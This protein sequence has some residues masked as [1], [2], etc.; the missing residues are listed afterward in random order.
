[1]RMK[2]REM[3][4]LVRVAETGSMTL[5]AQQMSLTPAAVSGALQRIESSIGIR[6]FERTTRSIR[7]TEEGQ[8]LLEGCHDLTQR[9]HQL[10]ED[11]RGQRIGL[12]GTV[13]VSAPTDTSYRI[14]APILVHLCEQHPKLRV[15]LGISDTVHH[16]HREGIDIAIR[17]GPLQDSSLSARKLVELPTIMVAAPSYIDRYG[18]PHHPEDLTTHRCVTLQMSDFMASWSL[19]R[20]NE[21][22]NVP[23]EVPL[24]GDGFMVRELAVDGWGI[25]LK[26]LFDV[27][28]DLEAG[29]LVR[30][31]PEYV[32][33]SLAIHAVFPS[34][35]Y[36]PARVRAF[37]SAIDTA[38]AERAARC[39]TWLQHSAG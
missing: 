15:L 13:H 5:A 21:R 39:E 16:M 14:L 18:R 19:Y 35:R 4:L 26:S 28:D 17:Y 12:E 36:M 3:E 29:R 7:P 11:A 2:I 23:I 34:R 1:M 8:V 27:I 30:I 6:V 24:C 10:L 31:L 9:W 32:G 37:V 20:N 25:T 33:D 22:L 38:F